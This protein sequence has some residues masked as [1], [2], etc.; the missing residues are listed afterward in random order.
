ME[1]FELNNDLKII[2]NWASSGEMLFNLDP[3]I[4]TVEILLSKKLEKTTSHH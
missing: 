1:I 4:Q 2:S 3:N